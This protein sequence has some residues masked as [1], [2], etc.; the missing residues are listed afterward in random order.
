MSFDIRYGPA[1]SADWTN[2]FH[3]RAADGTWMHM[4]SVWFRGG[5]R[6]ISARYGPSS[7]RE[8]NQ[9]PNPWAGAV[10]SIEITVRVGVLSLFVDGAVPASGP[11]V[12]PVSVESVCSSGCPS[13]AGTAY[14]LYFCKADTTCADAEIRNLRFVPL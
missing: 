4:P 14:D 1:V 3:A 11:G 7:Y 2:L 5:S 8:V 9:H 10:M 6:K 13:P 12:A